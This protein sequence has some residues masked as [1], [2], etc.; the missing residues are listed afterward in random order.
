VP[1]QAAWPARVRPT[2]AGR[3]DKLIYDLDHPRADGTT[4]LVFS[5]MALL[6]RLSWLC[7]L[8]RVHTTHYHGVLASAHPWRA[9]VVPKQGLLTK[10]P[11]RGCGARWIKWSELIR[12]VFLTDVLICQTWGGRRR[13][14]QVNEGLIAREILEHL[15]LPTA[16]T[17]SPARAPDQLDAWNTGPPS[18]VD[19]E[20]PPDCDEV[21]PPDTGEDLPPAFDYDQRVP[22]ADAFA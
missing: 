22:E 7:V 5:P 12:R 10:P 19:A 8:P 18:W 4:Q 6:Q 15:G 20:P 14:I 11:L 1:L 21:P 16:P 13:I 2:A 9:L 3:G 17:R